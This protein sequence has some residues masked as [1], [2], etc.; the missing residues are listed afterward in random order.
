MFYGLVS[1]ISLLFSTGI[2]PSSNPAKRTGQNDSDTTVNET[3][4]SIPKTSDF[5]LKGDTSSAAWQMAKWTNV[6]PY[7]SSPNKYK[8]RSKLLYSETGIYVLFV[9]EDQRL[10]NTMQSDMLDLWN[11]DVVEIFIQ[12]D[13]QKPDY[14]EYEI[15]PL[16]YELPLLIYNN[17]KLQLNSWL[18]FHYEGKRK[19]RHKTQIIGGKK[20]GSSTVKGW[21][22]EVF[23]PYEI[24]KPI[25]AKQPESGTQW[26]GNI[27]R[28]DYDKPN[29]SWSWQPT[30]GNFHQY[31]RFG[32]FN[33]E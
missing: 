31:D 17:E 16:D 6:S 11:E 12:P 18:P 1:L 4:L 3:A 13:P 10:T 32:T 20:Q 29:S 5:E 7:P 26:K 27:F 23:I 14:F 8:T 28:L 33:F 25:M 19:T 9:C 30:T 2:L 21:I 22:A 15:S 24:L